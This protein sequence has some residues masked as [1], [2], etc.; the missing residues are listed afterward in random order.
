MDIQTKTD[1]RALTVSFRGELDH[2][3][4]RET[5]TALERALDAALPLQLTLDFGG[6][7]F[8][9]SSGIAVVMRA[10]RRMTALGGH[11]EL[12]NVPPQAKKVFDAAG[13]GSRVQMEG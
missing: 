2:H 13:I 6:V 5:V 12:I 10:F 4:A 1:G 3:A 8:M 11:L 9:D 7:T